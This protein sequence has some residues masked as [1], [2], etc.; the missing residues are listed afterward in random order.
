MNE[1]DILGR[2]RELVELERD[3]RA[4]TTAGELDPAT[5]KEQLRGVEAALDQ[6]WDLLRQRRAQSEFGENPDEAH[7][8]PVEQVEKYLQ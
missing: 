6:C 1:Q 7:S 2:V 3:L 5:E 8:R 4:R